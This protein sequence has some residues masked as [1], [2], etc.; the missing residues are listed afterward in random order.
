M[1]GKWTDFRDYWPEKK[2]GGSQD[3][4]DRKNSRKV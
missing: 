3:Q 1:E 4:A 2:A